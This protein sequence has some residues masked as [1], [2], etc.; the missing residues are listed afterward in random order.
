MHQGPKRKQILTSLI[1]GDFL[2]MVL[3]SLKPS[4]FDFLCLIDHDYTLHAEIIML[5]QTRQSIIELLLGD[6]V[7]VVDI[8]F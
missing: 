4:I 5:D 6:Q 2:I 7:L 3:D 8:D 1:K